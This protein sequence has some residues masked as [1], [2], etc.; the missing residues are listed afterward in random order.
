MKERIKNTVGFSMDIN[1]ELEELD[2]TVTPVSSDSIK[3]YSNTIKDILNNHLNDKVISVRANSENYE[4]DNWEC[5]SII[6]N[7]SIYYESGL[8]VHMKFRQ[9]L[10]SGITNFTIEERNRGVVFTYNPEDN[11]HS[12]KFE[13]YHY[14][15]ETLCATTGMSHFEAE[16]AILAKEGKTMIEVKM[17][18]VPGDGTWSKSYQTLTIDELKNSDEYILN[19]DGTYTNKKALEIYNLNNKEN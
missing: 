6:I 10:N 7:T 16:N 19:D 8:D 18:W 12:P 2:P 5:A 14:D 11:S 1:T 13:Q 17:P 4:L 15:I 9:Y 3:D